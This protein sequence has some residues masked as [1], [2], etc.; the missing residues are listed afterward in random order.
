[1]LGFLFE[2]SEA[3]APRNILVLFS[4]SGPLRFRIVEVASH[5]FLTEPTRYAWIPSRHATIGNDI[6]V[7]E[8]DGLKLS[9]IINGLLWNTLVSRKPIRAT[10][11]ER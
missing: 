7:S 6:L 1:M 11:L 4:K 10:R 8:H 9:P 2:K 3:I 5:L